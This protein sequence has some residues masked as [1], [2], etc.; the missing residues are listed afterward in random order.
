MNAIS[1]SLSLSLCVC[2]CVCVRVVYAVTK[3]KTK[4]SSQVYKE[5]GKGSSGVQATPAQLTDICFVIDAL[6]RKDRYVV[7][8]FVRIALC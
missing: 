1:L 3:I 8:L 4:L 2:V 7:P 5:F 6:G